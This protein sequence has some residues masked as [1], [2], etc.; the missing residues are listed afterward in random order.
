MA[1][2][3]I[4]MQFGN[5]FEKSSLVREGKVCEQSN[6]TFRDSHLEKKRVYLV[7]PSEHL[8]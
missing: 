6:A 7:D 3:Q 8:Y 1:D 4:A 5:N 2:Q